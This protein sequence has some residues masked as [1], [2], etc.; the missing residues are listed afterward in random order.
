MLRLSSG[1]SLTVRDN[2]LNVQRLNMSGHVAQQD[3]NSTLIIIFQETT[4]EMF[5]YEEYKS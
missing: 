3:V 5:L 4:L 1:I 2:S